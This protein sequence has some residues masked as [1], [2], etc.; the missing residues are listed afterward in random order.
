MALYSFTSHTFTNCGQ[1]QETGPTLAQCKSEY[2]PTWTDD[3]NYFNVINSGTQIWTVPESAIYTIKVAG[4][5]GGE[6]FSRPN[7]WQGNGGVGSLVEANYS[8]QKGTKLYIEVGHKGVSQQNQGSGTGTPNV[9]GGGGKSDISSSTTYSFQSSGGGLSRVYFIPTSASNSILDRNNLIVAGAGGGGTGSTA[10]SENNWKDYAEDGGRGGTGNPTTHTIDTVQFTVMDGEDGGL[11]TYGL[12]AGSEG[13]KGG[14]EAAGGLGALAP[15][16]SFVY[17]NTRGGSGSKFTGGDSFQ[18]SGGHNHVNGGGGGSGWYGGGGGTYNGAAGAGG[19]TIINNLFENGTMNRYSGGNLYNHGYVEIT[20][21]STVTQWSISDDGSTSL[22]PLYS[23]TSHTFTNCGQTQETGPTLAQCK[24]EYTP[25]WTDDTNYFNVINA[26][27]QIWTVPESAIYTIKVAGGSG[28]PGSHDYAG[29][30]GK[31][32]IVKANF[33]I[34]KG[35]KM[36]IEVGHMGVSQE[37]EPAGT[38]TPNVFGGGGKS[39]IAFSNTFSFQSSG[40]GLSRVYFIPTSASGTLLDRNHLIIA[41]GG[42]GSS[43]SQRYNSNAPWK[44]LKDDGGDGGTGTPT[45][46]TIDTIQFTVMDG[47]DAP[48][49]GT[50]NNRVVSVAKGG[51]YNAGGLGAVGTSDNSY[52]NTVGSPGTKFNGGDAFP[53]TAARNH[54]NGGGGGSGWYGGGGASYKGGGGGGGSSI[55]NNLFES[56]TMEQTI[57]GINND[58]GYVEITKLSTVTQW[59]ISESGGAG[60]DSGGGDS[61]GG[62]SGGGDNG[63]GNDGGQPSDVTTSS[64]PGSGY[65]ISLNDIKTAYN[66]ATLSGVSDL[67]GQINLSFFRGKRILPIVTSEVSETPIVAYGEVIFSSTG[68]QSWT[69]PTDVYNVSALAIGGGGGGSPSTLSSNG[70]S[71]GGGGGGALHWKSFNVSPGDIYTIIVGAGGSG[72]TGAGNNNASNGGESSI[73][74]NSDFIIR[75]GGGTKG[76]YGTTSGYV[77]GGQSYYD[78]IGGGGGNGGRGG[79]GSN[80]NTGGGGGGAGGYSGN[81][82]DGSVGT[83]YNETA[84]LGGGGGGGTGHNGFTGAGYVGG[85]GVGIYGQGTSG[86]AN[87][88]TYNQQGNA[89]SG[90]NSMNYGGG[91]SGAEDDS[92]QRGTNGANGVVRIVWPGGT[93]RSFPSTKVLSTSS[94]Y[95]SETGNGGQTAI[96]TTSIQQNDIPTQGELSINDDFRGKTF[97]NIYNYTTF[98]VNSS[99]ITNNCYTIGYSNTFGNNKKISLTETGQ[100]NNHSAVFLPKNPNTVY[101]N[102]SLTNTGTYNIWLKKISLDLG[103]FMFGLINRESWRTSWETNIINDTNKLKTQKTSFA[104]RLVFNS[105][106]YFNYSGNYKPFGTDPVLGTTYSSLGNV[107]YNKLGTTA[108]TGGVASTSNTWEVDN[109]T[110]FHGS[111]LDKYASSLNIGEH[112]GLR[113]KYFTTTLTATVTNNQNYVTISSQTLTDVFSGMR[114]TGTSIPSNTV[115]GDVYTNRIYLRDEYSGALKNASGT[116]G[117]YTLTLT[118]QLMQFRKSNNNFD[119]DILFGP[120]HIVLPIKYSTT[121]NNYSVNGDISDWSLFIGDDSLTN[122]DNW[123]FEIIDTIPVSPEPTWSYTYNEYVEESGED[124]TS[125]FLEISNRLINDTSAGDYTG[126][127]DVS[128]TQVNATGN[129]SIILGLKVTANP[130]YVNDICIAGVQRISSTGTILNSWIFSTSSG[131]TGSSWETTRTPVTGTSSYLK[132]IINPLTASANTFYST[133]SGNTLDRMCWATSTSSSY[134]G[135]TGGLINASTYSTT[136]FP[137]G[138]GKISQTDSSYYAYREVSGSTRYG[139]IFFKSPPVNFNGT[140][141]IKV[142]HLVVT[143]AGRGVNS[144]D[145]LWLGVY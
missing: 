96:I 56:G 108:G 73:S 47:E 89:G 103:T 14:T 140:D 112:I 70:I 49:D 46:Y 117:T 50:W 118:G 105:S 42:G 79:T 87:K 7:E 139:T 78:S 72:G 22:L 64:M 37:Q 29:V 116:T 52:T 43:G 100:T 69:V 33:S 85:G 36:Y 8:I 25:S 65:S 134:T 4:G 2:T 28:G 98:F 67:T 82:G 18:D 111:S 32:S 132:N 66:F 106:G 110:Y 30:S 113:I 26:G 143:Q 86:A 55:V 17:S 34:E 5:S 130:T 21:V 51:T 137:T 97:A 15:T 59:N 74:L 109:S 57:P 39:D 128:E 75:A 68:S 126:A 102:P 93:D 107:F 62:D 10:Y 94:N 6:P 27:T 24:S 9:F 95:S 3:T 45:T 20:K 120:P 54:I 71:G 124:V 80:G 53:D 141:T 125:A 12:N 122:T 31:G 35:T 76:T 129:R 63:G 58:H 1:T 119:D 44:D 81:G 99:Y 133:T 88:T 48:A 83:S 77:N 136:V 142:A 19:S 131:G 13:A 114:V 121:K 145:S 135:A 138:N 60:G 127:W 61:G 38:E 123:D 41:A 23:F 101:N 92:G 115:L 144:N 84:G 16:A 90:G 104:D 11:R 40:G 91:G